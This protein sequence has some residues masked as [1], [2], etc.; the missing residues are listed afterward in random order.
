MDNVLDWGVGI[1][2]WLQQLSPTLDVPFRVITFLGG[3][4]FFLLLLPFLFWCLD[5]TAGTRLFYLFFLSVYV[6]ALTKV[7]FNQP[8]PFEYDSR[9]RQ[10]FVTIGNGFPSIHALAVVTIWGYLLVLVRHS[11]V[12][13]AIAALMALIPLSRLYLGLHFPVD[14]LGGFVVGVVLLP[15]Y[16]LLEPRITTWLAMRD[17]ALRLGIAL[18][19]PVLL[20]LA[21]PEREEIGINTTALLAGISVGL[22]LEAQHV[23]LAV[24]GWERHIL[25]FLP[26]IVGL[27][28]LRFGLKAVFAGWGPEAVFRFVRYAM[29]GLWLG[30]GA[31]WFFVKLGLI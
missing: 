27:F 5:R 18:G 21:L 22:V 1:V 2:L 4:E 24:E 6:G 31:P 17:P 26:G 28:V 20:L 15:L 23:H 10:L 3:E 19:L 8:R 13:V 29:M 30:V 7:L 12:W 9:V 16:L 11:W 14:L 25:R